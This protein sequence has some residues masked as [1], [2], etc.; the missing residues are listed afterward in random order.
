EAEGGDTL[1]AY[2]EDWP[3]ETKFWMKEVSVGRT[4]VSRSSL[5]LNQWLIAR[6]GE[7][8]S[9][10]STFNRFKSYVELETGS[11]MAELLPVIKQQA[12][13]YERWTHAASQ[14]GGSLDATQMAVYRMQAS[15]VE[16][17]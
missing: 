12:L 13:Q 11:K 1:R 5:F 2:R 6:T 15:G 7:E 4:L 17:L 8:V 16:V 14:A 10:Q 3:F 9:P